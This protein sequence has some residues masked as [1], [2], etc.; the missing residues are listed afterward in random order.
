MKHGYKMVRD[1]VRRCPLPLLS[2]DSKLRQVAEDMLPYSTG[3]EIE[4]YLKDKDSM[5]DISKREKIASQIPDIMEVKFTESELRFRIPSGIKGLI[6]L[7]NIS[8][9]L[10]EHALINPSS[11]VHYHVD[12]T[13]VCENHEK[14]Y[15]LFFLIPRDWIL[16]SLE[17]WGYTGSFNEWE[18]SFDKTAV[19]FHLD[20]RT[21]EFRI[22]EMT[23]DYELFIKRIIH[24]QNISRK[25]KASLKSP[26]G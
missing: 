25:I 7:Y 1:A 22:G 16:K 18:V 20:Y 23:F 10:K 2:L 12:F 24:C 4:C 17:S 14:L 11:G 3:I 13:D 6:C 26:T 5:H 8:E 9:F 15:S 21:V 19:K